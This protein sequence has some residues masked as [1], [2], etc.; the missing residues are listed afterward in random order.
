MAQRTPPVMPPGYMSLW[1]AIDCIDPGALQDG[2][3]QERQDADQFLAAVNWGAVANVETRMVPPPVYEELSRRARYRNAFQRVCEL[4][5]YGAVPSALLLDNFA[6]RQGIPPENWLSDRLAA[7]MRSTGRTTIG[8]RPLCI[9]GWVMIDAAAFRA[10]VA[11]TSTNPPNGELAAGAPDPLGPAVEPA[12]SAKDS[13]PDAPAPAIARRPRFDAR[14]AKALL[15][16]KKVN[17]DWASPPTE[18]DSRT[19]LLGNFNG[20]PNEPHRRIRRELWPGQIKT[21]PRPKRHAA[22]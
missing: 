22:E 8:D 6:R 16:A 19:F 17:G 2:T 9:S 4:C 10:A 14:K 5:A 21:G 1:Q 15:A 18:D 12:P 20:V 13:A 7:D 11:P 3:R